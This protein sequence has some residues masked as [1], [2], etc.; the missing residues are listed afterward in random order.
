MKRLFIIV[1]A[2]MLGSCAVVGGDV[3]LKVSNPIDTARK[4]EIVEVK[5]RE[6]RNAA[7]TPEQVVVYAEDGSQVPS[8]VLFDDM[9]KPISLI[10]QT[11][12]P[13]SGAAQ[14]RVSREYP[15]EY[16]SKVF[17]R[18]VPERMDDYAWENNLTTYRIYGPALKDPQTQGV[19]VWVK[20]TSKLIINEWFARNDYHHNYGEGMDCYKV[21]NTL[22][23]GAL[24]VVNDGKLVL[25]GNYTRQE[26]LANGP[27][28]TEAL[29]D[30]AEVEVEGKKVAMQRRIAL[31]ADSRF[32][33]QE[34]VFSGFDGEIEV[35]AGIVMHNVKA[36]QQGDNWVAVTEPASDSKDPERDGDISLAVIL[37]GGERCAQIDSHAA[38]VRKVKAGDRVIM[39]SGSAWSHAGVESPE[40]WRAEVEHYAARLANPLQVERQRRRDK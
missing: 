37:Q 34:Y 18:Y 21:G 4:G 16:E 17:G 22:G 36:L 29:F 33:V 8:Q 40:A 13:A 25:S 7:V 3:V 5:W 11:D 9:G 12:V 6:L 32:T 20:S 10:F 27:L 26:C 14:Y 28:R 24:A 15:E 2:A 35:A 38:V 1:V 31:D 30:Y 23:G 39:L 19:D